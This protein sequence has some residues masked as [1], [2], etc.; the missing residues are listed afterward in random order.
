MYILYSKDRPTIVAHICNTK[1]LADVVKNYIESRH[2]CTIIV[3]ERD[4]PVYYDYP[5][6]IKAIYDELYDVSI[7]AIDVRIDDAG[8]LTDCLGDFKP[9][10]EARGFM[11]LQC[12]NYHLC[13]TKEEHEQT[14]KFIEDNKELIDKYEEESNEIYKTISKKAEFFK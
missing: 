8:I 6:G 1:E 12:W 14:K 5:S 3:E 11:R 9:E 4:G 7:G 13:L 2:S 10:D